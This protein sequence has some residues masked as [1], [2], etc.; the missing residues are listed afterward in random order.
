MKRKTVILSLLVVLALGFTAQ[1]EVVWEQISRD[2][3]NC[4]AVAVHPNNPRII[5]IGNNHGVFR[6]ED[7][8][9]NWRNVL[10]VRGQNKKVNFLIFAPQDANLVYAATGEG[11]FAGTNKGRSWR[12][13]FQGKGY[14]ERDCTALAV[15]PEALYL[16]TGA[17]IFVSKDK[18]RSWNKAMG[19]VGNSRI[20]AVS[21]NSA[22]YIFAACGDGVYR[23]AKQEDIW[24]RVFVPERTTNGEMTQEDMPEEQDDE[25]ER[26]D[27]KYISCPADEPDAVY[28]ATSR[29]AYASYNIGKEWQAL[30]EYGLLDRS[31]VFIL[32][33]KRDVIYGATKRGV[34]E[35][36]NERWQELSFG[37]TAEEVRFLAADNQGNLYAACDRGLFKSNIENFGS[38]KINDIIADYGRGEPG[39]EQVQKA[40]IKYAEV[41]PEKIKFWRRQAAAKAILP[42]LSAGV[43]R[44]TTDLWHWEGGSTTKAYDDVLMKGRDALDWD[45]ALSWDLS[46]LIWNPDQTSID[47]R[48][49]LMVQLRDDILDE[50]TKL[51]FERL[52]LKMEIDDLAMED[53]KKRSVKLLRLQ[54]LTASIDALT[55]GYFSKEMRKCKVS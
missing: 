55:G 54:E 41:S 9:K 53:R 51:Y 21:Y 23:M 49:K 33:S 47:V 42:K 29:G 36:R 48:S 28:L 43:G 46:E 10:S 8:G 5:L 32:A 13:I 6:S 16:G 37:L 14:S 25:Q 38:D 20:F 26:C 30:S 27:I 12:R 22:G 45:V 34:F 50:V 3:T 24:E 17:G 52:R 18:G 39:I 7:G 2:E 44:N 35:Y 4:M 40:A 11:L 19:K 1:A 31:I 15:F